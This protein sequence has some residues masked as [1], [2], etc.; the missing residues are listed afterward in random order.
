MIGVIFSLFASHFEVVKVILKL[1]DKTVTG[2]SKINN[3][4]NFI[5]GTVTSTETKP[6]C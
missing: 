1:F 4:R 5:A 3:S 6:A 2:C